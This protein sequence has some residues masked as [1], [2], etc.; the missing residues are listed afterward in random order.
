MRSQLWRRSSLLVCNCVLLLGAGCGPGGTPAPDVVPVDGTVMYNG[1]PVAGARITLV[2]AGLSTTSN[3]DGR[4]MLSPLTQREGT[5]EIS[6][7]ALKRVFSLQALGAG[8]G[9]AVA[10]GDVALSRNASV[11]GE[12]QLADGASPGGTLVFLEGQASSA[13]TNPLGQ[14]VLRELPVGPVTLSIFRE[15]YTPYR[16]P[17]ELRSGER[18]FIDP[19]T[20][21][22]ELL[23]AV[24]VSGRAVFDDRADATGITVS[25]G[26]TGVVMSSA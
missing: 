19:V 17:L 8:F 3:D 6:S 12:V 18:S 25:V 24:R 1:Q 15:G 13:F 16:L 21:E 22:A 2:E 26:A 11:Q 5:L 9:R 7:G 20:L 14:F 23:P 4:F 10:M